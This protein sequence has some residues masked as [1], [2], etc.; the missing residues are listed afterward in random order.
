MDFI[1]K[2]FIL[3]VIIVGIVICSLLYAAFTQKDVTIIGEVT[4]VKFFD[5]YMTV[6]FNN[7]TCY[8][9]SYQRE[10]N[11]NVIDLTVNSCIRVELKSI[12][13]WFAPNVDDLWDIV[14]IVKAPLEV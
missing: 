10:K 14:S 9:I 13:Y 8:N 7:K 6:E 11:N 3:F 4:S 5:D 12:S 2:C 1:D